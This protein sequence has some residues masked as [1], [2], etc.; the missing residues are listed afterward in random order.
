MALGKL[1]TSMLNRSHPQEFSWQTATS[2]EPYT[3]VPVPLRIYMLGRFQLEQGTR[4]IESEDWRN[5]K[6]RSLFKV[7]LIRR[8][9][10]ISRQEAAELLWPELEQD[11]AF[12]N[13]NQ[14]VYSLRRTLQPGLKAAGNSVYLKTEG[15]RLRLAPEL[16]GWLDISSFNWLLN[17]ASLKQELALYEQAAALYQGEFLPEDLYEDWAVARREALRSQ[18]VELLMQMASLY[19]QQGQLE[20]YQYSLHRVLESDFSNEPALQ[21]LMKVLA[22]TG[23]R[24]ESLSFYNNYASRLRN[25]LKMEPLRETRQLYQEILHGQYSDTPLFFPGLTSLGSNP[26]SSPEHPESVTDSAN[27]RF[28]PGIISKAAPVGHQLQLNRW[29]EILNKKPDEQRRLALLIGEAGVG[30]THLARIMAQQAEKSGYQVLF[31]TCYSEQTELPYRVISELL[32]KALCCLPDDKREEYLELCTPQLLQIMPT[33]AHLKNKEKGNEPESSTQTLF[34]GIAQLLVKLSHQ[35]PYLL[36]FDDINFLSP[37]SMQLLLY[38]LSH[39][40]LNSLLVL[41]TLRPQTEL[42]GRSSLSNLVEWA[43]ENTRA[44][45]RVERLKKS[46]L[47]ALIAHHLKT[48]PSPAL[49]ESLW[50]TS[51]GNPRIALELI[52]GIIQDDRLPTCE[53]LT[54]GVSTWQMPPGAFQYVKRIISALNQEAQVLLSLAALIGKTFNFDTIYQVVAHRSDGSGWWINLDKTRLGTTLSE[55]IELGLVLDCGAEYQFAYPLMVETLR[56]SMSS[57]QRR[58]WHS[59]IDWAQS[60]ENIE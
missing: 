45:M 12:N 22:D 2:R 41:G 1:D 8:G 50:Q 15:S 6:S 24:E 56:D 54:E 55:L 58:C 21:K 18:W 40:G 34:T 48:R 47:E 16:I 10:Q 20:K 26:V 57:S 60:R 19:Q 42:Y 36:V 43:T 59:V 5:G 4:L 51:L 25:R 27:A 33:L 14:A 39:H 35:R 17:Q 7:L 49:F 44:F 28:E 30:K 53:T 9:Y 32:E 11:R 29:Q 52:E 37:A 46:E 38:L 13:L 31:A 3:G 23:R